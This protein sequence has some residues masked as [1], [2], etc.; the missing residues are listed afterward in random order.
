MKKKTKSAQN[1]RCKR[2][3]ERLYDIENIG[4]NKGWNDCMNY[5]ARLTWDEAINE[6]AK[7]ISQ[8]GGKQ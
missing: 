3:I 4:Y 5:L 7:H 8:K 1:F 2:V 6:I